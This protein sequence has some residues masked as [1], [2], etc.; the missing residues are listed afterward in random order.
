MPRLRAISRIPG[1]FVRPA[2][3]FLTR[4][5][6]TLS[7]SEFE[8]RSRQFNSRAPRSHG[9]ALQHGSPMFRYFC[10]RP[11]SR[12]IMVFVNVHGQDV[13]VHG[14]GLRTE[15]REA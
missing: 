15:R 13:Y 8:P 11:P 7:R 2:S 10:H 1:G 14:L 12:I 4:G 6:L 3:S 5:I 9:P